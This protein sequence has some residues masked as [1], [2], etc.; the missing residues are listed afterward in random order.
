MP[1]AAVLAPSDTDDVL[2]SPSAK[3]NADAEP[4]AFLEPYPDAERDPV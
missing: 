2:A 4:L 1:W 3:A